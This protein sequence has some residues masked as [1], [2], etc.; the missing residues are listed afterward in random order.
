MHKIFSS[1]KGFLSF[2]FR[3]Y[4]T[5]CCHKYGYG[6]ACGDS[7]G[8]GEGHDCGEGFSCGDSYISIYGYGY[9]FG[10]G[11][12]GYRSGDGEIPISSEQLSTS[13]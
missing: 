13:E 11:D 6:D 7:L 1:L 12:Y 4:G 10:Y 8:Y 3:S 9:G 2:K 5:G